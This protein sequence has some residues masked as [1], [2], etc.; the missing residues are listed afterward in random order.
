MQRAG[1]RLHLFETRISP[2][3][4]GRRTAVAIGQRLAEL[5]IMPGDPG[6]GRLA[7][8]LAGLLGD[9]SEPRT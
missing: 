7:A 3:V 2:E 9:F 4:I 8:G 5:G 1:A 6:D